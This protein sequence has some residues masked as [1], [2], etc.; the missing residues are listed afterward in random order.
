[1]AKFY[2]FLLL[3]HIK[4]RSLW[5]DA[6]LLKVNYP[7]FS[8]ICVRGIFGHSKHTV[9]NDTPLHARSLCC[10]LYNLYVIGVSNSID[11]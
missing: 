8:P 7:I 4:G 11:I 10:P 3:I 5:R 9:S 1:M 2:L 6:V